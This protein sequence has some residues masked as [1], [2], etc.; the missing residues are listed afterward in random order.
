[1]KHIFLCE[2]TDTY[3]SVCIYIYIYTD[4]YIFAYIYI[5]L[6][7]YSLHVTVYL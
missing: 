2:H 3:I 5:C 7:A 4:T 6:R 1:M